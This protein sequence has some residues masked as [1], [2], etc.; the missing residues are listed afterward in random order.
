MVHAGARV[1]HAA[2]DRGLREVASDRPGHG[3][4]TSK[5]AVWH[6]VLTAS[7]GKQ[8][9]RQYVLAIGVIQKTVRSV[10]LFAE[11]TG[12]KPAWSRPIVEKTQSPPRSLVEYLV[13]KSRAREALRP[14]PVDAGRDEGNGAGHV[15]DRR[16][17]ADTAPQ[18]RGPGGRFL[19]WTTEQRWD[20]A[21][22]A[23]RRSPK[24]M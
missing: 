21:Q 12:C 16:P 10:L 23:E 14:V 15:A 18:D 4:V 13:A 7:R 3:A 24:P 19:F 2:A 6:Q 11:K 8:N 5:T 9:Q 20:V 1:Q 22:L 17:Q